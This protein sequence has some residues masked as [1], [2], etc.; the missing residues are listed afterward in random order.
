VLGVVGTGGQ[1]LGDVEGERRLPAL[2]GAQ[3][4][5][6]QT[7][8]PKSTAPKRSTTRWPR[9]RT[10]AAPATSASRSARRYQKTECGPGSPTPEAA[11]SGG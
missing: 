11:D 8:A 4:P 5:S 10:A 9:S 2:V 1:R 3:Q 6:S 7:R